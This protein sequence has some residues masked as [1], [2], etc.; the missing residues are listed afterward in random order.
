MSALLP[1][2][3]DDAIGG[4]TVIVVRATH[5]EARRQLDKDIAALRE[6]GRNFTRASGTRGIIWMPSGGKLMYF[7]A[8]NINDKVRGM[9]VHSIDDPG[10]WV[11]PEVK[12]IVARLSDARG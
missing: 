6:A 9:S 12:A 8:N 3:L 5:T 2:R 4:N 10:A 1:L 11:R 7:G